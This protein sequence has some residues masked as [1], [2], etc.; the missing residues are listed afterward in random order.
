M[1]VFMPL[2]QGFD[3]AMGGWNLLYCLIGVTIGM[4]VG[5][6]PGLGPTTGTA[7]LLPI[8]FSMDPIPA[9][10]MLSG[11]YYGSLYGGTVTS[12]LINTPGEAASVTT[13]FDGYPMARQGRAGT[14]LGVAGIGSFI[15]G[16][17]AI[18]GL[19]F[20]GPPLA[21]FALK[22]GPP[23]FFALMILGL[24]LVV[25]LMGKSIV[26]GTIAAVVGLTLSLIG[27]DPISGTLRFTFGEP[28]LMEGFDFVTIAMGLF[29]ISEVLLGLETAAHTGKPP[30][31]GKL[32]PEREEWRPT[33]MAIA[34][35]TG[36]GCLTGLIPGSNAVIP[37][38]LSY[39]L[40]KKLAKDPSRFGQGAIEGVAG[41][42]TANN[43]YCGAALI[44]LFTMGIPSSPTIA[45]LF[46][47]FIMHGLTPGPALFQSN[48]QFVWAVI[49]SMFIGN[50][51]LL[52]MNLPMAGMWGKIATVPSRILYPVIVIIS[53]LGAYSVSGSVWDIWVMIFFG[54]AG[55]I[56]KKIDIPMAPVVLTFVLGKM[57]ESSLL[58]S[59]MYFKGD[60][61]GFFT[62]PIAGSMLVVAIILLVAGIVAGMKNKR[63]MLA[64]D[65]E[66]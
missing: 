56:M 20:I 59:L 2:L 62:R 51:M 65:F 47:A 34:R 50:F 13:C 32:L 22:F 8:T 38:I 63:S 24:V 25:G 27:M 53:V 19:V 18:I 7:L 42:E 46:G 44:P 64:D 49:A 28:H 3:I 54:V 43:A 15:G 29:G 37:S 66:V 14:A 10:I 5:V 26:R 30:K 9:I 40:E 48:P 16:T 4:L 58:Q 11:I 31:V 41:P 33:L 39:T 12:V 6:L 1:D 55:Y 45:V 17:I 52:I 60:F 36:L 21:E 57:I 35:G 23:E 61:L